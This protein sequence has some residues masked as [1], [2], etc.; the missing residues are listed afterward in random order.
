M[1]IRQKTIEL[2]KPGW[3]EKLSFLVQG[4]IISVPLTFF[5]ELLAEDYLAIVLPRVVAVILL[6]TIFAPFIEEFAKV[7]PLFHRHAETER[8]I[9]TLGFYT[10]LG[11]GIT[12]FFIYVIGLGV[13]FEIRLPGIFFHAAS[14]SITA[15]GVA[16]HEVI[17]FYLLAVLLHASNNFFAEL[18][19]LWFV[20]GIATVAMAYYLSWRFYNRA[21]DDFM[22]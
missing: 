5:F 22:E 12:E 20:G 2:H 16:K 7:F 11:F 3:A 18:G 6:I 8:S 17:R 9:V 10:G 15:Y 14:T 19:D 13:P 1:E 21:R 4:I